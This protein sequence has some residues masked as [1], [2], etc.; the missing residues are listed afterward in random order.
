VSVPPE[1]NVPH[2][3]IAIVG[4]D[5]GWHE[6]KAGRPFVDHAPAGSIL[7]AALGEAGLRRTDVNLLN[8]VNV[9]PGGNRFEAH[10]AFDVQQG[11]LDLHQRLEELQPSIIVALGNEASLACLGFSVYGTFGIEERRGYVFDGPFGP[12]LAAIH[13]AAIARTW[14]PWRMLLS[15][16][17]QRAKEIHDGHLRRPQRQVEV[18]SSDGGARSAVRSLQR[19]RHLSCDIET[20]D[21]GDLAC[22]GFAGESGKAYVFPT[23][24]LSTA[25]ELLESPSVTTVWANGI[26][27]LFV[28]RHR[29]GID[30]QCRV[31][32]VQIG[33][34]AAYPELAGKKADP[35]K[36]R[37]TRK[38]LAFLASLC[39]LD[40]WWK[41]DYSNEYEFMVY[42]GKDCCITYDVWEFV[43]EHLTN[44]GAWETYEHE[45][46]L[47]LPCV[48]MLARGLNVDDARR[49]RRI[50]AL[51]GKFDSLYA[52]LNEV[53]VPMIESW[54]GDKRL[55]EQQEGVCKCCR[56]AKKKQQRCWGCAG[57][58]KAPSKK[59]LIS[60]LAID[61]AW[62]FPEP[63]KALKEDLEGHLLGVCKVCNGEP[64]RE[65]IEFNPNSHAQSK[66]LLY[67]I[68][69]LPK[70]MK[71]GKLTTDENALKALAGGLG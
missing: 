29:Y 24:Y 41:G 54:N 62:D 9:K 46:S 67:D 64:R 43:K 16:D 21:T 47:M 18:I 50:S 20:R 45:R 42:N 37:M 65:W 57:F 25:R 19:H 52:N 23:Q 60:R 11:L 31:E 3:G 44:V 55:F 15:Y 35:K 26:Y 1:I 66:V 39:T 51:D 5:P 33:W 22:I 63:Q 8:V 36:R 2:G 28:L 34:H 49:L 14:T 59:E 58:G 7:K 71:D 68:L 61:D 6:T 30:I 27:D 53:A 12:V 38:S 70:K 32:D 10:K 48:D 4:R 17:L 69:R 40:P 13:P 56:H